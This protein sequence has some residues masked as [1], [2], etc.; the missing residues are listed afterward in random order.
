MYAVRVNKSEH[1][2]SSHGSSARIQQ[3]AIISSKNRITI[4]PVSSIVRSISF[5]GY[6]LKIDQFRERLS[7]NARRILDSA[8]N[9]VPEKSNVK[10]DTMKYASPDFSKDSSVERRRSDEIALRIRLDED[11][12]FLE[13]GGRVL[14]RM[15]DDRGIVEWFED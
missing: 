8:V 1:K 11:D 12:R 4:D 2:W 9:L 13:Y 15:V 3:T 6:S 7:R 5:F 14:C 10:E